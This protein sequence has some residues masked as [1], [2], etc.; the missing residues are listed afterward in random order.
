ME[1]GKLASV[2][3][4]DFTLP[5]DAASTGALLDRAPRPD[6][7]APVVRI[8]TPRWSHDGYF[9]LIY[10]PGAKKG[11]ALRHYARQFTTIELNTTYYG[12]QP[13][14]L[15]RW[16]DA[17]PEGFRFC[18][19]LPSRISHEGRLVDVE[20]DVERFFAQTAV[21]RE[22]DKLG[23]H[24]L[25]VPPD[26]GPRDAGV[27]IDFLEHAAPRAPLAVELRHADWFRG[28]GRARTVEVFAAMERLGVTTMLTDVAGRRD[29]LHMRLTTPTAMV[30]LVGNGLHATDTERA[31]AWARRLAAW[32]D[33]G[34]HEA[35]VFLHQP[36]ELEHENV[37]FAEIFA[38]RL[39][40]H[41]GIRAAIPTRIATDDTSQGSLFG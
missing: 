31:D 7:V 11:D 38:A 37:A 9:G 41:A 4:V 35:Y 16:A 17:A 30:R 8:G 32:F 6:D 12:V 14:S 24:W 13:G 27:L 1:F 40:E 20:E 25:L 21:F 19:K 15:E 18:P 36:D 5:P 34:L 2:D 29:V 10:P 39:E 23:I 33:A 3:H 22:G 26:F 28:P